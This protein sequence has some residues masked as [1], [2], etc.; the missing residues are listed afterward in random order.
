MKHEMRLNPNERWDIT[1][2]GRYI[3]YSSGSPEIEI[4]IDGEPHFLGVNEVLRLDESFKAF[5]VRNASDY[6]GDIVIKTGTGALYMAGDGQLTEVL[7]VRE[8]VKTN[9][10]NAGE[11]TD[12]ILVALAQTLTANVSNTGDISNPIVAALAQTLTANVSNSGDISNPIVTALAQTLTASVSNTSD[13]SNPIVAA[14]AQTLTANVSNTGDISNPI[15]AALAQ[16]LETLEKPAT[17][18]A[19]NSKTFT[20]GESHTIPANANRRDVTIMA[21]EDNTDTVTVAGI[22]L[23][24]GQYVELTKYTGAVTAQAVSADDQIFITEVIK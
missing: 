6:A 12:P 18:L 17:S 9:M 19:S 20:A 24:A 10:L 13:I 22:P 15:V 23:R 21:S 2:T 3:G 5:S 1:A 7:S 8:T 4:V 14:L 16:T 11:I